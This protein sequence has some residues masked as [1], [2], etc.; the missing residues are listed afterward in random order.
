MD[1]IATLYSR[2][3][4]SRFSDDFLPNNQ[5][6]FFCYHINMLRTKFK[7]THEDKKTR[8]NSCLQFLFVCHWN[9][10]VWTTVGVGVLFWRLCW[11]SVGVNIEWMELL[12]MWVM[13]S[14]FAT[15]LTPPNPLTPLPF[16]MSRFLL[17]FTWN[18]HK[19]TRNI[20][21][22]S[23]HWWKINRNP[24][25]WYKEFHKC[26]L[27][28]SFVIFLVAYGPVGCHFSSR[29][30]TSVK[31]LRESRLIAFPNLY[32]CILLRVFDQVE[33]FSSKATLFKQFS[34]IYSNYPLHVSVVRPSSGGNTYIGN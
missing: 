6:N 20:S 24:T 3:L 13:R 23:R 2:I 34:T 28:T 22:F 11:G 30:V 4:F 10:H 21:T 9:L 16:P 33:K 18:S 27:S 32:V 5:S 7:W 1:F 12:R 8:M 29:L 15:D 26:L 17:I 19:H 14:R 25:V 31:M